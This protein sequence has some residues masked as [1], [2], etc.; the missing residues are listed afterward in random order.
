MAT[1][2]P[3]RLSQPSRTS[4]M[5]PTPRTP[6]NAYRPQSNSPVDMTITVNPDNGAT[7][8]RHRDHAIGT[9]T[10]TRVN[11]PGNEWRLHPNQGDSSIRTSARHAIQV[12]GGYRDLVTSLNQT[13]SSRFGNPKRAR[14]SCACQLCPGRRRSRYRCAWCRKVTRRVVACRSRRHGRDSIGWWCRASCSP[15]ENR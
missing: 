12:S 5:P 15:I 8:N 3:R 1:A 10:R 11:R 14:P 2:R 6:R 7:S 13:E 9:V 4:A